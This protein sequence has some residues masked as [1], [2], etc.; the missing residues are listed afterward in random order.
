[1]TVFNNSGSRNASCQGISKISSRLNDQ[2][3]VFIVDADY[4]IASTLA[5]ILQQYGLDA[6]FYTEPREALQASR[7][8]APQFLVAEVMLPQLS[9]VELAIQI[10]QYSSDCRVL[11]VSHS[12]DAAYILKET[13]RAEGYDFELLPKP[14]HPAV[15][16]DMIQNVFEAPAG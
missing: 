8:E 5:T 10:L 1:M 14:V 4:T 16:L 11:L 12:H 2:Y 9:G 15:L 6:R 3:R 13:A 7:S